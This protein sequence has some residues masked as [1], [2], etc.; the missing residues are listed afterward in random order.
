MGSPGSIDKSVL[1][2]L[3]DPTLERIAAKL[4]DGERLDREDG[5]AVLASS[6]LIGVGR[7][8][9]AVKEAR[10]GPYAFF[11]LNRQ[12]NPTNV[13]VIS[14]KFCDFAAKA[15][16]DDAY[17]M[18]M[19]E[20]LEKVREPIHEV[21]LVGGLHPTWPFEYYEEMLRAIRRANP[22]AQIK[23]FTAVEIEFF[24]KIAK[25][26]VDEVLDRLVAAGLD[27][28]PG[29]GA[30]VFSDRIRSALYREKMGAEKWLEIHR[31]AHAK[32]IRTNATLL[33]GHIE[34]HEERVDHLML[35]RDLQDE[36]GGFVSFI[37]LEFQLGYT[38]LVARQA[39]AVDGLKTIAASRLLLDNFPHIKAYWVMLGEETASMALQWGAD[40]L[41][42]TIGEEKIAHAALASSP[43][44]LTAH[45]MLK[46]MREAGRVPVQRDARYRALTVFPPP[47]APTHW[48]QR[49]ARDIDAPI[50]L[51]VDPAI[52]D[53]GAVSLEKEELYSWDLAGMSP[54]E[55]VARGTPLGSDDIAAYDAAGPSL[56]TATPAL[57]DN[58]EASP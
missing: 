51:K 4:E 17:E 47:A 12:I 3:S 6:D 21:H 14:C 34:T 58:S 5:L 7:L 43:L 54:E 45:K 36:T 24:S 22:A 30:E 28:M 56:P 13:C 18:T 9:N 16:D 31:A 35:L 49:G 38:N 55:L 20:I 33:Y 19:D 29:G 39:S 42:G 1:R 40:D 41:D 15:G 23:A 57:A 26:S 11:V 10:S 27:T 50:P 2:P 53:G 48:S 52:A 44:G 32:G 37:P 8:A 46:L 25:I